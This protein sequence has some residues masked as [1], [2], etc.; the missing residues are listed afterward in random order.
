MDCAHH[1][2]LMWQ[3]CH[4]PAEPPPFLGPLVLVQ[5]TGTQH[6]SVTYNQEVAKTDSSF[7]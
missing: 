6:N 5:Y 4:S 1:H 2:K 7:I 3:Q